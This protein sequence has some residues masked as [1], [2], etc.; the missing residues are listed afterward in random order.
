M[1]VD[2][3]ESIGLAHD[4]LLVLRGAERTFAA[5]ADLAPQAPI[6]TLLYDQRGTESRFSGHDVTTSPLQRLGVRQNRFRPFLPLLPTL[7]SRLPTDRHDLVLSSSSAFAHGVKVKPGATHVCYCHTPFRYAW[8]ERERGMAEVPA[9]LRPALSM[10]L[11]RIQRWDQ[12]AAQRVT[13]YVANSRLCQERIELVWNRETAIVHPPVDVE[14]FESGEPEDFFLMVGE[15]VRHKRQEAALRAANKAGKRVVVV[16]EGPELARLRAE[17]GDRH[18][19][20][21]RLGD[22]ELNQLYPRALALIVPNVEEF[23]I[24]AVE[25][26]AAGR[27]VLGVD[28]GGLQ[29]TVIAGTTGELVPTDDVD[30]LAEALAHTDFTRYDPGEIRSNA[31]RFSRQAFQAAFSSE[32]RLATGVAA[33]PES[34]HTPSSPAAV[35]SKPS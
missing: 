28:A 16:G 10:A 12:D 34:A 11:N 9:P 3:G 26:Q 27:P 30:A 24:A 17:Y 35:P 19:F 7:A 29:E 22:E 5:M 6:Y 32:V 31:E 1:I 21:G 14:R 8:F 33:S 4:Y 15:I 13:R 25:A 2:A 20:L 18:D 23:G